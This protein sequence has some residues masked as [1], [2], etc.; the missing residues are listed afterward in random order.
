[1]GWRRD[2]DMASLVKSPWFWCVALILLLSFVFWIFWPRS[3]PDSGVDFWFQLGQGSGMHGLDLIRV[4]ADGG[5]SYEYLSSSG[6]ARKRFSIDQKMIQSLKEKIDH[7]GIQ[8][9]KPAYHRPIADGTQWC[10]LIKGDGR[11]KAIYCD[12]NFPKPVVDLAEF[13]H[14]NI[15][16]PNATNIEGEIVT[17]RQHERHEKE[18]WNSIRR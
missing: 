12:N 8:N 17:D 13:V 11:P 18:L 15:L 5:V 2:E 9:L 16:E 6:W 7:L 10:L 4:T 1:M 14:K 3:D